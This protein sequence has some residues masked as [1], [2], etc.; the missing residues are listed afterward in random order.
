MITEKQINEIKDELDHCKRP[1]FFF[2]DDPDGLCSF[3][4]FYRYTREGKGIVI[5]TH[6]KITEM[7]IRKVDEYGADKVFVLDIAMVDQ[8]FIDG[9]RIPVV[10]VDHHEPQERNKVKYYNP[11][12]RGNN[13]P[14][15][16]ICYKVVKQDMWI[17]M[18]GCIGDW[19]IPDFVE[20]FCKEYPDLMDI[21]ITN[22]AEVLFNT[23]LG[24]LVKILSFNMKGKTQDVIK[25]AKVLTRI[26]SPYEILNR[27]TPKGNYIYKKY[28]KVRENYDKLIKDAVEKKTDD[29]FLLF[30][31]VNDKISLTK[32]LANE[33]LYKFPDKIVIVAREK[34]GEMKCSIRTGADTPVSDALQRALVGIEGYG[35]GHEHAC[36]AVIKKEDFEKFLEN[37]RNEL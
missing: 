16:E 1:I 32:D 28:Q 22:P 14:P 33:L 4:L 7:F 35:G 29:K 27:T 21:S 36:G 19:Y 30:P 18:A 31:Y 6:P 2:H 9:V 24:K 23:K 11:R 12:I 13:I 37:L 10:W 15:S 3:L 8:E 20:E 25:S 17:S 5:K 26:E 34:S